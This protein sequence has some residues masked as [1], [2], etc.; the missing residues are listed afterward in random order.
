MRVVK[1]P[2]SILNN[3]LT[4]LL[5]VLSWI[6]LLR[7]DILK[8]SKTVTIVIT[9]FVTRNRNC[10]IRS[11]VNCVHIRICYIMYIVLISSTYPISRPITICISFIIGKKNDAVIS[12]LLAT[13][14]VES[15]SNTSSSHIIL[16][17]LASKIEH[18]VVRIISIELSM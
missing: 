1:T 15:C 5:N 2:T 6:E 13:N 11:E 17:N 16:T 12:S 14:E 10:S 8:H 9:Y 3:N 4:H 7:S 18:R